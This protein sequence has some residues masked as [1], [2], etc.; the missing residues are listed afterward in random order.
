ML[1][2]CQY[3]VSAMG[4]RLPR[5]PLQPWVPPS[6]LMGPRKL[7]FPRSPLLSP[8]K[9][10][11]AELG[12]AWGLA[13]SRQL[14]AELVTRER[15]KHPRQHAATGLLHSVYVSVR[16]VDNGPTL[17]GKVSLWSLT[18][19]APV[20]CYAVKKKKKSS[21]RFLHCFLPP[22]FLFRGYIFLKDYTAE[23]VEMLTAF[24][25]TYHQITAS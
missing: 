12:G 8:A 1:T 19:R 23:K 13:P 18:C 2:S 16:W 5:V 7:T 3:V 14:G 21:S 6:H 4:G 15:G 25:H 10:G 24:F 17:A 9:A 20:G 11:T 22:G